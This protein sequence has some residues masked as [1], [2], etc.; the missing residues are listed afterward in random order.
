MLRILSEADDPCM[1]F[2][3]KNENSST[4]HSRVFLYKQGRKLKA[5]FHDLFI[6]LCVLV[7][8]CLVS[9]CELLESWCQL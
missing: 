7:V 6:R 2:I 9:D 5:G 8:H 3:N 1:T 4:D